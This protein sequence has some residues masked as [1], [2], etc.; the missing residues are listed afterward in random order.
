[1]NL[2]VAGMT[3]QKHVCT[4]GT[5]FGKSRP[6]EYMMKLHNAHVHFPSAVRASVLLLLIHLAF[7]VAQVVSQ[8]AMQ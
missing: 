1:M 5:Q 4:L 7:D 3:Q 6:R 8:L 2:L